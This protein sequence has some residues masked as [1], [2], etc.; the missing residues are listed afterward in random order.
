MIPIPD[1]IPFIGTGG[2]PGATVIEKILQ[3]QTD[4]KTT[5]QELGW[6]WAVHIWFSQP[7]PIRRITRRV[8]R[9]DPEN[10]GWKT[11]HKES[12][13]IEVSDYIF[14]AGFFVSK[15]VGESLCYFLK[16]RSNRGYR[17]PLDLITKYEPVLERSR[18]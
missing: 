6:I 4:P 18:R 13:V 8:W 3:G 7:V 16:H 5:I 17:L 14:R 10:A 1:M 2:D 12:N 15:N 9:N 11:G